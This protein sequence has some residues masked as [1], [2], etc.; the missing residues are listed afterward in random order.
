MHSN[1]RIQNLCLETYYCCY[2]PILGPKQEM[3]RD[4]PESAEAIFKGDGNPNPVKSRPKGGHR[5]LHCSVSLEK[6]DQS[7]DPYFEAFL[8][9]NPSKDCD[10]GKN[11]HPKE[12]SVPTLNLADR[13]KIKG[14]TKEKEVNENK[15]PSKG[16]HPK[17]NAIPKLKIKGL[18]KEQEFNHSVSVGKS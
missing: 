12:K 9:R 13:I 16:E 18:K 14:L 7:S 11:E 17:E 4:N 8:R 10:S 1:F 3:N 15:V 5:R 6:I 2:I